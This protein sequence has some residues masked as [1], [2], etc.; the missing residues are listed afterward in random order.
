MHLICPTIGIYAFNRAK[1]TL[2]RYQD[3]TNMNQSL[4]QRILFCNGACLFPCFFSDAQIL[5]F[6]GPDPPFILQGIVFEMFNF[7]GP[8]LN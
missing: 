6:W 4:S 7:V 8:P 2:I 1:N 5:R 3:N